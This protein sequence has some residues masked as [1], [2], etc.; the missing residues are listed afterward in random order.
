MA[1]DSTGRIIELSQDMPQ[2]FERPYLPAEMFDDFVVVPI[3]KVDRLPPNT[4][5]ETYAGRPDDPFETDF[6]AER[7]EEVLAD[8]L[9]EYEVSPDGG[10]LDGLAE[11]IGDTH[12][13]GPLQRGRIPSPM[14]P[15]DCLAFYLPFHNFMPTWWGVY[16]TVEGVAILANHFVTLSGGALKPAEAVAASRLFLYHHEAFHHQVECFATRLELTH[17][18]PLYVADFDR[19]YKNGFGTDA[20]IEE[21]LANAQAYRKTKATLG[22]YALENALQH[23]ISNSPPG[24]RLGVGLAKRFRRNQAKFAE[25]NHR[26]CFPAQPHSNDRIWEALGHMFDGISNIRGRVNYILSRHSPLIARTR[27]KPL[28]PP[29]K[30]VKKIADYTSF[31]FVRHGGSHDIYRAG[32]GA[33]VPIPRHPR[34]MNKGTVVKILRESGIDLGLSAFLAS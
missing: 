25:E 29:S 16:L 31:D 23:Y 3:G 30:L 33:M 34:D 11:R 10:P 24:Y 15:P 26:A 7:L 28:L 27:I 6:T 14:P 4:E 12:R 20:C 32:N 21:G 1:R 19:L 5:T 17:R 18:K 13:G 8:S 22:H 9:H 2:V